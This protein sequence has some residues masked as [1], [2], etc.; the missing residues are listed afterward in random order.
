M[1]AKHLITVLRSAQS[2]GEAI[3]W[4]TTAQADETSAVPPRE[5]K[6]EWSD[7]RVGIEHIANNKKRSWCQ[8]GPTS[9]IQTFNN[10]T[11]GWDEA[12]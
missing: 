2:I 3:K 6:T 1:L 5:E 9:N 8:I 10:F 7:T 12:S 11:P 4:L